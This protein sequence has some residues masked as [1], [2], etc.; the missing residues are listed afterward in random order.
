M[1]SPHARAKREFGRGT[2][3]LAVAAMV[4]VTM[5]SVWAW[6]QQPTKAPPHHPPPQPAHP[7]G[8]ARPPAAEAQGHEA[9]E[10]HGPAA[11]NWTEFDGEAPPF[12]AMLINFGILAAGYF[13][14]GKEPILAGLKSRRDSVAKEIELAQ[15]MREEAEERAKIYQAKLES[16]EAEVQTARDALVR[17]GEAE[18]DRIVAEAEAK[19]ERMHRDAL[20]LVEQELKQ[21]RQDLWREAVET[22][23]GAAEEILKKRVTPADQERLAEAFLAELG[24]KPKTTA[25][26]IRPP[27]GAA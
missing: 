10:E 27:G 2:R 22:A 14:I 17:A 1:T 12:I 4:L 5:W 3:R 6:G 25:A 7:A 23:V 9:E 18:R 24:D 26:S 15:Q 21:M 19:A 16:L 8:V 20:F 11:I 13:L